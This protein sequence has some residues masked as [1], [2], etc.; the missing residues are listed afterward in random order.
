MILLA[1]IGN[2]YTKLKIDG[3]KE[4]HS[5]LTK[6]MTEG[7]ISSL[8]PICFRGKF[9]GAAISSV[10]RGADRILYSYLKEE[11][12]IDSLVVTKDLKFDMIY[13]EKNELGPDL[14][15]LMEGA[16]EYSDTFIGISLGT[17]SVYMGVKEKKFLGCAIA[18]GVLTSLNGLINSAS[19]IEDTELDGSYSL[20]GLDTVTSLRSGVFSTY[21]FVTDGYIDAIKREYGIKDAK[22][23]M[24][25]GFS[26]IISGKI[27]N[28]CEIHDNLI[29]KGLKSIYI[30]NRG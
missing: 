25:G 14:M 24:M 17:A 12:G 15:C 3:M 27:K 26:E 21:T 22:V 2:T 30:K 23:L 9:N 18:P 10:V 13:P 11:F 28:E 29:F 20:L 4:V 7:F 5:F 16:L 8:F 1:D 6:D 19:L